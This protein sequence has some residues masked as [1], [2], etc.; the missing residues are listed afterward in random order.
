MSSCFEAC[1]KV[2]RKIG[3]YE[4]LVSLGMCEMSCFEWKVW[5]LYIQAFVGFM[6]KDYKLGFQTFSLRI[7]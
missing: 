1:F 5:N 3:P 4:V 6:W 7:C 2:M